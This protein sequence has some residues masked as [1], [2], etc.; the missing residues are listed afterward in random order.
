MGSR[1]TLH[2]AAFVLGLQQ[3]TF[4]LDPPT[5]RAT[6]AREG[7]RKRLPRW[8][9]PLRC[10]VLSGPEAWEAGC[11]WM[12]Y[13]EPLPI[14][15]TRHATRVSALVCGGTVGTAG[16]SVCLLKCLSG[17]LYLFTTVLNSVLE[18]PAWVFYFPQTELRQNEKVKSVVYLSE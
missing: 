8:G 9:R 11:P 2:R 15:R 12:N 3:L 17:K 4:A 7:N 16:G 1:H 6:S 13:C 14:P 5:H 10:T 18:I